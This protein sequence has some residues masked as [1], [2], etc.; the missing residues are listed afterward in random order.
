[1]RIFIN[2]VVLCKRADGS[3]FEFSQSAKLAD[4]GTRAALPDR[5][6]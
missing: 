3:G 1:M 4:H 2:F 5:Y 6:T